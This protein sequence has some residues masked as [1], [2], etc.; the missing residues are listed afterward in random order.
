MN[1][2]R[3]LSHSLHRLTFAVLLALL[4]ALLVAALAPLSG[5][6]PQ[7]NR[8]RAASLAPLPSSTLSSTLPRADPVHVQ[9]LERQ[10]ML[11][12]APQ[13]TALVSGTDKTL[14]ASSVDASAHNSTTSGDRIDLLLEAADTWLW[15][16]APSLLTAR[17]RPVWEELAAPAHADI[18]QALGLRGLYVA[19]TTESGAIWENKRRHSLHGDDATSLFFAPHMGNETQFAALAELAAQ[20]QWQLGAQLP[21]P[22][23]G[24]G[25]DFFLAARNVRDYP[26]TYMML[27]A[28]ESLWAELPT[29]EGPWACAA[30][31]SAQTA[32][33]IQ[34]GLLPPALARDKFPWPTKGGKGGWAVTGEVRGVDGV[35]RRWLYRYHDTPQRPLLH[36]DDP[37]GNARKIFSAAII[38][39]VG[40]LQH[41][42]VSLQAEALMGLD[43][44]SA[45]ASAADDT[46]SPTLEP[47]PSALRDLSR[48]VRRYGGW[49]LHMDELPSAL[50]DVILRSGV[51]FT[52]DTV[53][54][55]TAQQALHSGDAGAL[56]TALG[57]AMGTDQRRSLRTVTALL[58]PA[59]LGTEDTDRATLARRHTALTLFQGSLPG[60]LMISGQDLAGTLNPKDQNVLSGWSLYLGDTE[61]STT[62]QGNAR[63]ATLY[64]PVP[65]QL[66]EA[67]SFASTVRRMSEARQRYGLAR[68]HMVTVAATSH[69]A[70]AGAWLALPQG[71]HIL[72]IANFSNAPVKERITPHK[73]IRG[74]ERIRDILS[75]STINS[76][77]EG[78]TLELAPYQCRWL[79]IP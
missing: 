35:S 10:S 53:L 13:L 32:M 28:P 69:K 2:C 48:E 45:E 66:T 38:R 72:V 37:S 29:T 49:S 46:S 70:V 22:A 71:G 4:P 74:G 61:A 56:R 6:A 7:K 19:P 77:S 11:G 21:P 79:L 58:G 55:P 23:T 17:M 31:T 64:P 33:L 76:T 36:W 41:T 54:G 20:R 14:R 57:K 1:M 44:I 16:H 50:A 68:A 67:S 75:E 5:C 62:R 73:Q 78:L 47:G 18:V 59:V 42:V 39:Q 15:V 52:L 51:D 43:P 27:E 26:G 65:Q 34:K 40:L 9:W 63:G 30:L 8:T 25:P 24:L 3:A 12:A 60:L